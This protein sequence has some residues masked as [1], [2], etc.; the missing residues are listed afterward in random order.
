MVRNFKFEPIPALEPVIKIPEKVVLQMS[1][2]ASL[3]YQL[4]LALDSGAL[5]PE[6]GNR[7]CGTICHSRWNTTGQALMMLWMSDHGLSGEVL[8]RFRAIVTFVCQVYFPMFYEIKVLLWFKKIN[9][10]YRYLLPR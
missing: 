4:L 6:L 8:R 3:C 5:S 2:D 10:I 9:I 1:T 7:L